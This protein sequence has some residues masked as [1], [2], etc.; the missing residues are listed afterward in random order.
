MV[1]PVQNS[2]IIPDVGSFDASGSVQH[3]VER[4][5]CS[6][7]CV[8]EADTL[9]HVGAH[10]PRVHAVHADVPP[11]QLLL[12]YEG[13]STYCHLRH[14]V[15]CKCPFLRKIRPV[16]G[17]ILHG[18]QVPVHK[19]INIVHC[20][21]FVRQPLD[22]VFIPHVT[23]MS[24]FARDVQDASIVPD[25]RVQVPLDDKEAEVVDVDDVLAL[26]V[27]E[28]Q[29]V[30]AVA[31]GC[32]VDQDVDAAIFTPHVVSEPG[33]TVAVCHIELMV[34]WIQTECIQFS[35]SCLASAIISGGE[36]NCS[37]EPLQ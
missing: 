4:S 20:Q 11:V 25:Q 10:Q 1:V 2:F 5:F 34:L 29:H 8:Q 23:Q 24:V 31:D 30:R 35:D 21:M 14:P 36:E 33:H 19:V 12:L 15:R 27:G 13:Q 3:Q 32:V 28:V 26:L 9:R 37:I 7:V 18:I 6:L 16:E 22:P 17:T